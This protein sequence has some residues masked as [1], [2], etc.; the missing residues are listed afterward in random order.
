[1]KTPDLVILDE[2]FS[3]MDDFVRDK[4]LLF[5]AWGE[6]RRIIRSSN[7]SKTKREIIISDLEN[8]GATLIHGLTEEQALICVSHL[9]EEV[10]G[11]V[12]QWICLPD[13]AEGGPA[14]FGYLNGPLEGNENGWRQIWGMKD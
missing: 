6:R 5:L 4:C 3:G 9:K 12:R 10:P 11:V 1:M 8:P 14:R 13:A 7:S 2:A